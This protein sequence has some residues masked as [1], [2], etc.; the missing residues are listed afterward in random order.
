[1]ATT[2]AARLIVQ[3]TD[4]HIQ[5]DS[6]YCYD[7]INT[8]ESLS[9]VI[10]LM[11]ARH[12]LPDALVLT[13][14]LSD[15]G[16][17]ASYQWLQGLIGALPVPAFCLPG[18]HDDGGVLRRVLPGG[19]VHAT[20]WAQLGAWQLVFL[21]S[22][23]PGSEGGSL[24]P[25]GRETL[26]L[27]LQFDHDTPTLVFLHHPPVP[28]GSPWLDTMYLDDA[29]EF[30]EILGR[31]PGV[32]AVVFGHIHQAYDETRGGLRLLGAPSTCAQ[33]TPRTERH[34]KDAL[35]PGYRWFRLFPDGGWETGIERLS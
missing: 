30:F 33:F 7:G 4:S 28:V 5:S 14:D 22:P 21:A 26:S 11:R 2:D 20:D 35:E 24:G 18:N 13:G 12:G 17:E 8:R 27:L 32:R 1:M 25:S 10:A 19:N 3:L 6:G 23:V 16:S 29:G 15:D 34:Q 9:A 31:H